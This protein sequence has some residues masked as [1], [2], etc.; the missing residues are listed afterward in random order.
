MVIF[1]LL[2]K[3]D[4]NK[5]QIKAWLDTFK[6]LLYLYSIYYLTLYDKGYIFLKKDF[7]VNHS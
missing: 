1:P 4:C 6:V 7:I 5:T 2:P 3:V